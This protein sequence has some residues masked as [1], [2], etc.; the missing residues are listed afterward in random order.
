MSNKE[1]YLKYNAKRLAK[2]EEE[3]LVKFQAFVKPE[4]KRAIEQHKAYEG[5][6]TIGQAL[7]DIISPR[8][9]IGDE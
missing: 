4:T 3:G 6:I 2:I 8:G 9:E 1:T 7:D 5:F